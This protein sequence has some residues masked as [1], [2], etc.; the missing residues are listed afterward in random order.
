ML[1]MFFVREVPSN[2][3]IL[4]LNEWVCQWN[5]GKPPGGEGTP[6][7][8][9][10]NPIGTGWQLKGGENHGGCNCSSQHLTTL[11]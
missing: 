10:G 7:P 9:A 5:P 3:D 1:Y 6:L 4:K 8:V 2:G 11:C